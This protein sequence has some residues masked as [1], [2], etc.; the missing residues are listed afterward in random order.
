MIKKACEYCGK[1]YETYNLKSKFCSKSCRYNSCKRYC[2]ICGEELP[3]ANKKYCSEK[4]MGI[5]QS[6]KKGYVE[7]KCD[8]CGELFTMEKHDYDYKIKKGQ[9]KFFCSRKC[10]GIY[11]RV[12]KEETCTFCGKIFSKRP[13]DFEKSH[14]NYFCS[15]ECSQK[16]S[17]YYINNSSWENEI[18]QFLIQKGI[19]YEREYRVEDFRF[20]FFLLD[21]NILIE[22]DGSFWHNSPRAIARDKKKNH[23][24]LKNKFTLLRFLSDDTRHLEKIKNDLEKL[25]KIYDEP[26]YIKTIYN[27]EDLKTK[28]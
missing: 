2:L 11:Q 18:G 16:Y 28:I 21:Y 12:Y 6:R 19:A 24:A 22:I 3:A 26:A 1:L 7:I 20:D 9:D 15:I 10:Y 4:C 13:C 27:R 14:T 23:I 25:I 8:N 17:T 5:A